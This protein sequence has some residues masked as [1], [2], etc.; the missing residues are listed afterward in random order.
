MKCQYCGRYSSDGPTCYDCRQRLVG[1][2]AGQERAKVKQDLTLILR[3]LDRVQ[4]TRAVPIREDLKR[5]LAYLNGETT[6]ALTG[7]IRIR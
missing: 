6:S 5:R 7:R 2:R 3:N 1:T 4:D